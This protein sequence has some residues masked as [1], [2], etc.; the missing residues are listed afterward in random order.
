MAADAAAQGGLTMSA[1]DLVG[2]L[3]WIVVSFAPGAVGGRFLPGEW[4]RALDKPPWTP[5]GWVFGPAWT[6]LYLSMGVAAWLVWR[7]RGWQ[8]AALPLA[9]YGVQLVLNGLWS[10][11][12]FGLRRP[13]LALA[14]IVALWAA[15]ATTIVTFWGV[16]PLAGA[17]LL[18][19]LAWVS[20]A[21]ALNAS[22]WRRNG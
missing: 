9:V 4:Y 19:Y 18:P 10:W 3:V 21:T 2:L 5:P 7:E 13:D 6:L 15:I 16:R 11:L 8:R 12:F 22:I 14:D 17:I 1:R 20:F